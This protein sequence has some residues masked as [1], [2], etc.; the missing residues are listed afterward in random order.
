MKNLC[1]FGGSFFNK[2]CWHLE[3]LVNQI[4]GQRFIIFEK[5]RYI[6]QLLL[7]Y[8]LSK[9]LLQ[10]IEY[11]LDQPYN[12]HTKIA[13]NSP[14]QYFEGYSQKKESAKS[15]K[16]F[17]PPTAKWRPCKVFTRL[18]GD[19]LLMANI[20]KLHEYQAFG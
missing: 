4:F 2:N 13:I 8:E 5:L 16:L 1:F 14:I 11:R 9:L 20:L 6:G 7:N 3:F 19:D 17:G 12:K 18:N 10:F 15:L